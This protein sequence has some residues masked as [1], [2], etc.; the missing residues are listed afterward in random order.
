[1]YT[2]KWTYLSISKPVS[3]SCQQL[4]QTVDMKIFIK[5]N[6]YGYREIT[7]HRSIDTQRPTDLHEFSQY[8]PHQNRQRH[9]E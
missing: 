7:K 1:M 5:L 9:F 4:S 3:H 2:S 8:L 6:Y